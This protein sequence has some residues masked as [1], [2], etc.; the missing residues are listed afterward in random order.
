[1]ECGFDFAQ[2]GEA[3]RSTSWPNS[4]MPSHSDRDQL[5]PLDRWLAGDAIEVKNPTD[6]ER[7]SAW[8]RRHPQLC[9]LAGLA[10]AVLLTVP[11]VTLVTQYRTAAALQE[12]KQERESVVGEHAQLSATISEKAAQLEQHESRWKQQRS[13]HEKLE[14]RCRELQANYEKSQRECR[15]TEERMQTALREARLAFA[16]DFGRQARELQ[17]TMPD[18]SLIL[19]AKA[20]S[21]TQQEGVAPL[22][23]AFQQ[24]QELLAPTDGVELRGHQGPVAQLAASR[25]GN[26][27]ASGD[28]QGLVRLWKTA[29]ADELELPRILEGQWGRITQLAFTADNRWL[30]SGS[31]DSNARIWRIDSDDRPLA[32]VVLKCAQGRVAAITA[33]ENSRR[34]A[35]VSVGQLTNEVFVRLWNLEAKDIQSSFVDLPSYQGQF[36]SLAINREGD[37]V[38][39]GN[40]D[41]TV[42]LWRLNN[43]SG[44]VTATELRMHNDPVRAIR[45]ATDGRSLITAGGRRSGKGTV[46][47][48]SLDGKDATA[49]TVLAQNSRGVELFTMTSDGRWLFTANDEPSLQVRDLAKAEDEQWTTLLSGPSAAVQAM[50]LSANERWLATVGADNTVRLWYLSAKGPTAMPITIRTPAGFISSMAFAGKGDWLATGSDRGTIRIWNLRVDDLIRTANS[51]ML[52]K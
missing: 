41:G 31:T 46:Q 50:A 9:M 22:P 33:S 14:K 3:R 25:D 52:K 28:H 47:A 48:W 39:T 37:W 24:I 18:V 29:S 42:R 38:A 43:T 51:R 5:D 36:C 44:A 21:I 6:W 2:L 30:V 17:P 19:A 40:H 32:P 10:L 4:N 11:G 35:I 49:D 1:V 20:L 12:V 34:I 16:E 13:E 23:T 26:W 27:L 15:A 45:F 8:M 7:A